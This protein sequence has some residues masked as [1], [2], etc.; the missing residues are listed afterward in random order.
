VLPA[1]HHLQ[2]LMCAYDS[3]KT[4]RAARP[5]QQPQVDLG[6]TTLRARYSDAV[7]RAQRNL[8]ATTEGRAMDRGDNGFGGVFDQSLDLLQARAFRSSTELADI[9]AGDEGSSGTNQHNGVNGSISNCCGE[10]GKQAVTDVETQGIHG[11]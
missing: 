8:E 7:V 1:R 2:S 6:E 5:G 4:L 3:R 10:S 11:R 9:G